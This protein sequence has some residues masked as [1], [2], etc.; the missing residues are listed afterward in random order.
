MVSFEKLFDSIDIKSII[1]PSRDKF[2]NEIKIHSNKIEKDDVYFCLE[3]KKFDGH[4][5]AKFAK[6]KGAKAIVVNHDLDLDIMQIV[7]DDT[8]KAFSLCCKNFYKKACDNMKIIGV[9]GT[10][11]KTTTS[12]LISHILESCGKKTALIG[13]NGAIWEGNNID[14]S[15]T[16]PDPDI[17]HKLFYQMKNDG[18][19]YVVME[20]SAHAIALKKIEGIIFEVAVM[21]NIT[22]DHLDFFET[23]ENYGKTKLDF[24]N[25]KSVLTKV[26]NMD[27]KTLRENIS[28]NSIIKITYGN[29]YPADCFTAGLSMNITGSTFVLNFMDDV[30]SINTKMCGNYNIENI[31][32]AFCCCSALGLEF[33]R[34]V[35]AISTF[36]GVEGRFNVFQSS[37]GWSAV[38]DY[39]HTPDGLKNVLRTA[40]GLA[41][42]RL[43]C[44]FGCGGDR[45]K[46]KRP[47]MGEVAQTFADVVIVTSDNPRFE[48]PKQIIEDITKGFSVNNYMIEVDRAK[49]IK[50]ACEIANPQDLIVICGKGAEDYMDIK[51]EKIHFS[52]KDELKKYL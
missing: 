6:D 14:Y 5:F 18:V 33:D 44:V 7:V 3:G 15:M 51:G 38:I 25:S 13:T 2:F 23:M 49:A 28:E 9:C 37:H 19:E 24:M 32:A 36:E 35:E 8:R 4:D 1:N 29:K 17:M 12:T 26:I 42:G 20:V 46:L 16:T 48:Q 40:G 47:I 43:I 31:M 50:K 11:G 52:D 41:S 34:I 39:A 45:D 30:F 27:D 10:N 21:T 22:E